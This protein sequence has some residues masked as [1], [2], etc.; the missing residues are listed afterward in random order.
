MTV[1][2]LKL[3]TAGRAAM[4][5]VENT[6]TAAIRVAQIGVTSQAFVP[7]AALSSLP[8]EITA[9]AL[10]GQ[11][12]AAPPS[13]SSSEPTKTGQVPRRSGKGTLYVASLQP[14]PTAIGEGDRTSPWD[15]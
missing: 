8:G 11:I 5:N 10:C 13:S 15:A 3:T 1:P 14:E 6:G 2:I 9:P 7:T 4:V 12:V